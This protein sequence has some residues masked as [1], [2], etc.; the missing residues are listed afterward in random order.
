MTSIYAQSAHTTTPSCIPYAHTELLAS[1][2]SGDLETVKELLESGTLHT[3]KDSLGNTPLHLAT[4]GRHH[5]V[6]SYLLQNHAQVDAQNIEKSTSLY[7]AV[8]NNDLDAV[9]MLTER[10][11]NCNL[12]CKDGKS[13][14]FIAC[15]QYFPDI[16]EH[17]I[18][19]RANL[20]QG[21]HGKTFPIHLL[22][23]H[24]AYAILESLLEVNKIDLFPP[25]TP[26]EFN[27]LHLATRFEYIDLLELFLR[28]KPDLG[29][30][31]MSGN[32]CLHIAMKNKSSEISELLIRS[33]S[34]VDI[35]DKEGLSCF[36]YACIQGDLFLIQL[37]ISHG[38]NLNMRCE[39]HKRGLD[40]ALENGHEYVALLL[41]R[42]K[43]RLD[44]LLPNGDNYYLHLALKMKSIA[45]IR[46]LVQKGAYVQCV[47]QSQN[48][49]LHVFTA[50]DD[51][52]TLQILLSRDPS[53][54]NIP[55]LKKQTPLHVA[56]I[57]GHTA[58]ALFFLEQQ[59]SCL[60]VAIFGLSCL[61]YAVWS[62]KTELVDLLLQ[63]KANHMQ[64][65]EEG[66]IPLHWAAILGE[67]EVV[68]RLLQYTESYEIQDI[69]GY[70][71]LFHACIY[72][73][74]SILKLLKDHGANIF[75]KDKE[76]NTLLH[77]ACEVKNAAILE[78]LLEN[79]LQGSEPNTN[80]D[81]ALHIAA[82]RGFLKGIH[83][84][85]THTSD[86]DSYYPPYFRR[87]LDIAIKKGRIKTS[88]CLL[89]Y[90]AQHAHEDTL[91]RTP[92]MYACIKGNLQLCKAFP[93]N[94]LNLNK[95]DVNKQSALHLAI[96]NKHS[97]VAL[98]LIEQ[99]IDVLLQDNEGDTGFDI[100]NRIGL[101]EVLDVLSIKH[102]EQL[103]IS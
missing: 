51:I 2:S 18:N 12:I 76:N 100:A 34:P 96:L 8:E 39:K 17:L 14:F 5:A 21:R 50:L 78:Y 73:Q 86:I 94:E 90:K 57:K 15:E 88:V 83:L 89:K 33:N 13:P 23:K 77:H 9:I 41:L 16:I 26:Q 91:G 82:R 84:L 30:L 103:K 36:H 29:Q 24:R 68:V 63:Y 61:S 62:R 93:I 55:N 53:L 1:C 48:T 31:D 11:A 102:V 43:A 75:A 22:T 42:N 20:N 71:P 32:T 95:Q 4:T 46:A 49:L 54:L 79:G 69:R 45:L 37:L 70:T 97:S 19:S 85:V 56:C 60:R 66:L 72:K 38:V 98:Y 87:P 99:G 44:I 67:E 25:Q 58:S 3:V 52:P 81:T 65:D 59:V 80:G 27:C 35:L 28:F 40:Y 64:E 6:M 101:C 47:D 7:R 92:F 10:G 74:L